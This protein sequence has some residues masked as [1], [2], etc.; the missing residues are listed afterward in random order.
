VAGIRGRRTN[1]PSTFQIAFM[2]AAFTVA[3]S[4]GATGLALRVPRLGGY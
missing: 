3:A 2:L 4:V 1:I